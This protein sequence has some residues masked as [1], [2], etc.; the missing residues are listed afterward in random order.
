MKIYTKTGDQGTTG[1]L[2][3]KRVSKSDIKIECFGNIDELN[4]Y[5][6]LISSHELLQNH[7]EFIQSVQ[8]NL[9]V[10]GSLLAA[11]TE[12]P[13][14]KL[15]EIHPEEILELEKEIDLIQ[16]TL[17]SLKYFVLPGGN[18]ASSYIHI[19]R[20]VCRRAERSIVALDSKDEPTKII[21]AYLNRLSDYLFVLARK[22]I[23]D[24]GSEEIF[25][26]PEKK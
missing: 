15:P 1:L 19:A 13:G 20:T 17:P 23:H 14:I 26:I 3:G 10:A 6:G 11:D 5:L 22:I 9:F 2:G 18:Q 12:K 4:S 16:E 21:L 25:W 8:N 7:K 24:T